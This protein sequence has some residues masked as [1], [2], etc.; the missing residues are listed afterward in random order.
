MIEE[1]ENI[2]FKK[3]TSLINQAVVS[4]VAILNK[5]G[6]GELYFG[7]NDK[8]VVVGQDVSAKTLRDISQKIDEQIEPKIYTHIDKLEFDGKKCIKVTF[9]GS[10]KPYFARGIAYIRVADED[11]R[12]SPS[13]LKKFIIR[14]NDY[15]GLW[16]KEISEV[17]ESEVNDETLRQFIY[18][19]EQSGRLKIGGLGSP[20]VLKKLEL[21]KKSKLAQ[22]GRYL[23]TEKHDIEVQAAIFAGK[24]K[25]TFLDIKAFRGDLFELLN[26][27]ELY[28]RE[29]INWRVEFGKAGL[30]RLEIPEIPVEAFR[31][32]LVNSIIHRDYTNPKSNEVAIFR[33]RIEV[34]NPGTFP[35]GLEPQDYIT[36]N[37]K[38]HLRN[39]KIAEIFY[40]AKKIEKWGSGLKRI[41]DECEA[42]GVK[43][44]FKVV[45][46]GFVSIFHR[47]EGF[48]AKNSKEGG[49]EGGQ[50]RWSE[51]VVRKGGQKLT[52]K[53]KELLEIFKSDPNIT[54]ERISSLL[55]IN[56]SAIQKRIK[57]LVVKGV[58]KRIGPDK[59]GYWE[60]ITSE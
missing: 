30:D 13:E 25:L 44:E 23:F 24:D 51:K 2:E 49:Q 54:R 14:A 1:N 21:V 22:A 40:Y 60:V 38:S 47:P 28:F 36:G 52:A 5:H 12:L 33:D 10:D 45:S 39:P 17:N 20:E 50:K 32:A 55:N 18:L 11:R 26:K 42:N 48:V 46:S 37:E 43:V 34:Y 41:Y 53:Q 57:S 6:K 27:A 7:I 19:A 3:S 58:L 35:E 59:G 56:N 9:E 16:D 4:I 29:H 31:E 8:G 15:A